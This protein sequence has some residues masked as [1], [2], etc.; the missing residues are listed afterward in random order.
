M[1]ESNDNDRPPE[2]R[3]VPIRA[4]IIPKPRESHPEV[5]K[6]LE[7]LLEMARSGEIVGLAAVYVYHDETV[8]YASSGWHGVYRIIG[9]MEVLKREL[10]DTIG[11]DEREPSGP[12][13]T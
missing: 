8:N 3:V 6:Q 9:C 10:I 7:E 5:V 13:S 11:E 1:S 12:T 4:G 2:Q